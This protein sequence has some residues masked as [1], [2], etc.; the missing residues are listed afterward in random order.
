[1]VPAGQSAVVGFSDRF[2]LEGDQAGTNEQLFAKPSVARTPPTVVLPGPQTPPPEMLKAVAT[3]ATPWVPANP[4][5]KIM[6]A[7]SVAAG[8]QVPAYYRIKSGIGE[9]CRDRRPRRRKC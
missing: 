1:V 3:R 6:V 9:S 5:I 2:R 8:G 4:L 7:R